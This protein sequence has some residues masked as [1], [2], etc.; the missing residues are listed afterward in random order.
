MYRLVKMEKKDMD[1]WQLDTGFLQIF[2]L[3]EHQSK[4][5]LAFLKSNLWQ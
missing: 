1:E 4:T 3:Y 2:F 5:T